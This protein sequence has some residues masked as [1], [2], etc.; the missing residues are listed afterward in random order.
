MR[1]LIAIIVVTLTALAVTAAASGSTS[2]SGGVIRTHHTMHLP[3]LYPPI[4]PKA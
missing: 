4:G 3:P 2:R 1:Q